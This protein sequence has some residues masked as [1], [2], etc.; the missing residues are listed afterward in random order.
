M[1]A[2]LVEEKRY[3]CSPSHIANRFAGLELDHAP[4]VSPMM[5]VSVQIS[6]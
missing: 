1:E 4:T 6:A 3:E 5:L 2:K